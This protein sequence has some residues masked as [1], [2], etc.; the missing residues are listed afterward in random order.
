MAIFNSYVSLPE[1]IDSDLRM[2]GCCAGSGAAVLIH[3]E[4]PGMSETEPS[5]QADHDGRI[6][7]WEDVQQ[8]SAKSIVTVDGGSTPCFQKATIVT[9]VTIVTIVTIYI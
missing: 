9:R 6:P 8:R 5:K 7:R 3:Y 2:S 1:G 4:S